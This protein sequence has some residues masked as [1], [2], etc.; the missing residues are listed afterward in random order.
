MI[1]YMQKEGVPGLFDNHKHLE[2]GFTT[3]N[4]LEAAYAE[5]AAGTAEIIPY[6]KPEVIDTSTY[7]DKR[8]KRYI[9][10]LSVEGT[11]TKYVGDMLDAL[12]KAQLGDSTALLAL[13]AKID[14]IKADIPEV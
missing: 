6:V 7:R 5:V 8:Q 1:Q 13:V 4:R 2:G 14:Q 3:R 9:A 10:E 11:F 12:I